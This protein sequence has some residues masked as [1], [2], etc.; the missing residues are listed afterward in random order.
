MVLETRK[1]LAVV[2]H[3]LIKHGFKVSEKLEDKKHGLRN[4]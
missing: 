4:F 2:A 1:K 3:G